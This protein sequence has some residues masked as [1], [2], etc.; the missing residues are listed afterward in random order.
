MD[1]ENWFTKMAKIIEAMIAEFKAKLVFTL[2][3]ETATALITSGKFRT[4]VDDVGGDFWM[5]F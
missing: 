3:A 5:N 4:F 1:A 2:G